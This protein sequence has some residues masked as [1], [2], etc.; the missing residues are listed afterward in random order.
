MKISQLKRER[1]SE[2][3]ITFL[4]SV[5]PK[6]IF[7]SHIAKEL[8]RDEEFT[9]KILLELKIKKLIIDIKQNSKGTSYLKRTKWKLSD[10]VYQAY[11]NY[12]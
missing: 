6:S 9:K 1:I 8:A 10:S 7:T 3:I 11:K 5:S 12:Q 4:Y 2:Q